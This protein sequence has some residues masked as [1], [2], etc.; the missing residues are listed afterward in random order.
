MKNMN[1]I[2]KFT[3]KFKDRSINTVK[4]Y[5]AA[6]IDYFE[7]IHKEPNKEYLKQKE[8]EYKK[9]IE[10]Y[11]K[12]I[13]N[14]A[15]KTRNMRI[16]CVKSFLMRNGI[17]LKTMF[18]RDL[19][20]SIKEKGAIT[21]DNVL[22]TEDIQKILAHGNEKDRAVIL[23]LATSGMRIGE[24]LKM[25]E[26]SL[27]LDHDPPYLYLPGNITKNGYPRFTFITNEAKSAV[28]AWQLVKKDYLK[29]V[30]HK[31][32]LPD[33]INRKRDVNDPRLFPFSY[34]PIAAR[35]TNFT[36]IIGKDERDPRTNRLKLHIHSLRSWAN[37]K[38]G[39]TMPDM[40]RNYIIGHT[41]YLSKE[42]DKFKEADIAGDY[43]DA[44]V[45]LAIL[46]ANPNLSGIN[47]S[48]K[49]K[50]AEI[51]KMKKH[52]EDMDMQLRKLLIDKLTEDNKNKKK[53]A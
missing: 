15:P 37:T 38:L 35:W 39:D 42:Y 18:Y 3:N 43:K 16:Y 8:E 49:E 4:T 20:D 14:H 2:E 7:A 26:D 24:L 1:E 23:V 48:L 30:Q 12:T 52:I 27:H 13:K 45:N 46:E 17:E 50:D 34:S 29:K 41:T 11:W 47:E 36:K 32:N 22:T 6:L 40:K 9:D 10:T 33:V 51:S 44:M 21:Q 19:L 31:N 28:I 5:R 25:K 53:K